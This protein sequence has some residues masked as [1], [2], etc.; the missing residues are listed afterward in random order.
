MAK[1]GGIGAVAGLL[2]LLVTVDVPSA[3]AQVATSLPESADETPSPEPGA[4]LDKSAFAG[5]WDYNADDSINI[6]TGRPEQ[7]PRSATQRGGAVPGVLTPAPRSGGRGGP[8]AGSGSSG[9]GEPG[10]GG[11]QG[12]GSGFGGPNLGPTPAMVRES[13]DMARDLLEV[14]ER[15]TIAVGAD[16]V[17]ITDDLE[18]RRT[19]TTSASKERHQ[20]AASRFDVWTEWQGAQLRQ[21]IEGAFDFKM[22]Q[23][24][25]LSPDGRRLFM[26]VRVGEP[27]RGAAQVG[28]NRVYDRVE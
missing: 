23:T 18:R 6:Q 7:R 19:Y 27:R 20:I 26:I 12:G 16:T 8:G 2:S 17:T 11:G 14:A 9:A 28:F 15:L 24:Y 1:L 13:R 10:G 3:I 4:V 21:R 5:T 25:F 22:T